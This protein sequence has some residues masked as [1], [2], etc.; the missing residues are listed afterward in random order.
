MQA[1]ILIIVK[2]VIFF[3]ITGSYD[4]GAFIGKPLD[5]SFH[6]NIIGNALISDNIRYLPKYFFISPY[7][8]LEMS[9]I[10][11]MDG[12]GQLSRIVNS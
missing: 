5:A 3:G 2:I 11:F 10:Y 6:K 12:F 7:S 8:Q 1:L 4:T 9:K